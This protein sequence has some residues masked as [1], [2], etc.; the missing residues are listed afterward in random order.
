MKANQ[1]EKRYHIILLIGSCFISLLSLLCFKNQWITIFI[2]SSL[3]LVIIWSLLYTY[4]LKKDI[5]DVLTKLSDL[6]TALADLKKVELFDANQD[7]LLSKIQLQVIKLTNVLQKQNEKITH[8]KNEIQSLIS[9]ISHQ[10][11]TPLANLKMYSDLLN[12]GNLSLEKRQE[13]D[14]VIQISLDKLN[15]LIESM[16]KMSRLESGIIQL[17]PT[18]TSL[19]QT[20]LK[21]IKQGMNTAKQKKIVIQLEE[22]KQVILDHDILWTTESIFNIL[23]NAIKYGKQGSTITVHITKYELFARI[24]IT[25]IG[26]EI[27]KSEQEQIFKR[28]Y[29]GSNTHNTEGIGIG[30]YLTRQIIMMQGGYIKVKSND[31]ATTFSLFLPLN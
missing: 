3:L 2:S 14:K 16:I 1:I 6:I 4:Q 29:R 11:K 31:Q 25:N 27:P 19:N 21:A 24:D 15:F 28:F 18:T 10:L 23:D 7:N 22:E 8:E 5:E 12:Q 26:Y 30:L 9:D 17:K 13:F 20:I